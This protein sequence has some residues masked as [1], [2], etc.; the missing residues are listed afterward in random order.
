M[1]RWTFTDLTTDP[2]EVYVFERNPREMTTPYNP[3]NTQALVTPVDG[4]ARAVRG[5]PRPG[6]WSF[7]GDIRTQSF[8]DALLTWVKKDHRIQVTDHLDRVWEVLLLQFDTIEQ[9]PRQI[10]PWRLTY[11]IKALVYRRVA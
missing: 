11:T 1:K 5:R 8:H 9:R 7:T 10:T 3:R 4:R 2:D 6:E